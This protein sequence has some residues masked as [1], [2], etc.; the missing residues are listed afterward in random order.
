MAAVYLVAELAAPM[1]VGEEARRRDI[2][3]EGSG[4]ASTAAGARHCPHQ[5]ET[6]VRASARI[7]EPVASGNSRW[8]CSR[9]LDPGYTEKEHEQEDGEVAAGVAH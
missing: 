1:E 3:L 9:Q 6:R 5:P 2:G 4:V 8:V 7:A